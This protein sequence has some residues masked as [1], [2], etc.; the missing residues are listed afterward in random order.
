LV[1][2]ASAEAAAYAADIMKSGKDI[3]LI[4]WFLSY[5]LGDELADFWFAAQ[6]LEQ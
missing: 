1:S 6:R 2:E 5:R 3:W 4:V